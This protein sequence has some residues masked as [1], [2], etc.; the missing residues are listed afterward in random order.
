MNWM[1][2]KQQGNPEGKFPINR[3]K[4]GLAYC[5][6]GDV[7]DASEFRKRGREFAEEELGRPIAAVEFGYGLTVTFA[8]VCE[9][10]SDVKCQWPTPRSAGTGSGSAE[11]K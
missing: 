1:V 4:Q 2:L 5:Y 11:P 10:S 9:G 7:G 3:D 8:D 6:L